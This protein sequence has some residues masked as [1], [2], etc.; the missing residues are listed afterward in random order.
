MP[1]TLA[2]PAAA[3]PLLRPMGR[4]GVLSAIV[5]GSITPDLAYLLPYASLHIGSHSLLGI[6]WFCLPVGLL[7]YV[8]FHVFLKGPLLGL[9][10]L[11]IF[12]RLGAYAERFQTLP[13]VQ[14]I[15]V[16]VSLLVGTVTHVLWDSFTH[17]GAPAVEL[18]PILQAHLFSV[19]TYTVYVFKLL[20]HLSTAIGLLLLGAWFRHWIKTSNI[21][22][23]PL[24][25]M[26]SPAW[27]YSAIGI[28]SFSSVVAGVIAGVSTYYSQPELTSF[29][30]L[31]GRAIFAA[32]PT[33]VLVTFAYSV[34]WHVRRLYG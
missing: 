10:P 16:A 24:P 13:S 2:H 22:L 6:L 5:I 26:L 12:S 15:S 1:F 7:T 27:R 18:L 29:H 25:L 11:N 14:W 30:V 21:N 20:Q 28:I 31:V 9:F 23:K 19:G 33:L 17:K 8:V 34:T 4:F 3:I 32:L